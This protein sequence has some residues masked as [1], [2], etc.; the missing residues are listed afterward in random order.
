MCRTL[1]AP[2]TLTR[3]GDPPDEVDSW[4]AKV[5]C[6]R[7]LNVTQVAPNVVFASIAAATAMATG[8]KSLLAGQSRLGTQR[9]SE[10]EVKT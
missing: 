4:I 10:V 5:W 8:S 2:P 1:A 6:S 9:S 3:N 7:P